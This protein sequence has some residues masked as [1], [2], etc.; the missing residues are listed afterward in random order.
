MCPTIGLFSST[1]NHFLIGGP[2]SIA[3]LRLSED[4]VGCELYI[5]N[6]KELFGQFHQK[7]GEIER[8]LGLEGKLDWQ[9]LPGRKASRIR[10]F[11]PFD[12]SDEKNWEKAFQWLGQTAILFKKAFSKLEFAE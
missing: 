2:F 10:T 4:K 5:G 1:T 8:S 12:L 7:K 9:E 6:S 11:A 3:L